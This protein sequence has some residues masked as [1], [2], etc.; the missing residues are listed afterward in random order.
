MFARRSRKLP[1][2][3]G[4][5]PTFAFLRQELQRK[6]DDI[7]LV[8]LRV[9]GPLFLIIG[10]LAAPILAM[11]ARNPVYLKNAAPFLVLLTVWLVAFYILRKRK[12]R[13][14]RRELQDLD[15]L[16]REMGR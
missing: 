10:I 7:R 8:W 13:E 2:D 9:L 14:L 16:E 5:S 11:A 6:S 15:A 1:A 3:A 12:R 4:L